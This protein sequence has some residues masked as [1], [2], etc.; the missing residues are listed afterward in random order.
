MRKLFLI[1]AVLFGFIAY[2]NAQIATIY[3]NE[4]QTY[5]E[6]TTD[7]TLTNT[8]AQYFEVITPAP[9]WTTQTVTVDMDSLAGNHTNVN[10]A[11]TG[12]DSDLMGW[13]AITDVD[14]DT[15]NAWASTD[16]TMVVQNA[17]EKAYRRYKVTFTGTGTGTTTIANFEFKLH[18]GTP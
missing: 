2:T 7:V 18:Y 14:W 12:R 15:G 13:T 8:T 16:T 5:Y 4:N 9:W 1:L 3:L 17:T 11:L 10:V 6:Y